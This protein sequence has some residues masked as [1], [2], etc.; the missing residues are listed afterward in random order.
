MFGNVFTFLVSSTDATMLG[1]LAV[2]VV[3]D[4]FTNLD[5]KP[6]KVGPMLGLVI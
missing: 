4:K 5:S 2:A 1:V 3:D 6:V